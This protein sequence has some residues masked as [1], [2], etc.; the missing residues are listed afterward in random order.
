MWQVQEELRQMHSVIVQA[1]GRRLQH[2]VGAG[3]AH[4]APQQ[5]PRVGADAGDQHQRQLVEV[6]E[7]CGD[8]DVAVQ[9]ARRARCQRHQRAQPCANPRL[10]AQ[11]HGCQLSRRNKSQVNTPTSI[12]TFGGC[13]KHYVTVCVARPAC[14]TC[15]TIRS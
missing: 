13:D 3:R 1:C 5:E 10:T 15:E 4:R 7:A 14:I 2:L 12:A 11:T 6:A 8:D 9:V